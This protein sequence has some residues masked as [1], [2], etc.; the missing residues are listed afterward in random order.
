MQSALVL[1]CAHPVADRQADGENA[2][3]RESPAG[4][5]SIDL[6]DKVL[7]EFNPPFEFDRNPTRKNVPNGTTY[8]LADNGW[9]TT[10][11]RDAGGKKLS[12][13]IIYPHPHLKGLYRVGWSRFDDQDGWIEGTGARYAGKDADRM[14][15]RVHQVLGS[16]FDKKLDRLVRENQEA[17]TSRGR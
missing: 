17:P 11:L 13:T 6:P 5:A 14:T 1:S 12:V 4:S 3:P 10:I 2:P 9:R 8:L 16:K 7:A 15:L